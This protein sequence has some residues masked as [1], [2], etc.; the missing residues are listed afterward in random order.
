MDDKNNNK[1]EQATP[2]Q[3]APDETS[4]ILIE[5]FI[6]IFDPETKEVYI[7]ERA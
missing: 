4:G 2:N 3:T 6:K 5:G 1:E 7:Q